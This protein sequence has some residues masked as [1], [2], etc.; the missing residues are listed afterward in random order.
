[1]RLRQVLAAVEAAGDALRLSIDSTMELEGSIRPAFAARNI[2][3][4]YPG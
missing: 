3:L 4:I 1:V 2:L